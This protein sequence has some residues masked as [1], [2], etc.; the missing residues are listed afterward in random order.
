MT[1]NQGCFPATLFS[2][3][4]PATMEHSTRYP[5]A[6]RIEIVASLKIAVI[7][8][9]AS[10]SDDRSNSAEKSTR[11]TRLLLLRSLITLAVGACSFLIFN[12]ALPLWFQPTVVGLLWGGLFVAGFMLGSLRSGVFGAVCASAVCSWLF[13]YCFM[14][15][16]DLAAPDC[17]L[18]AS[19][20]LSCG[21]LTARLDQWTVVK[22]SASNGG[23]T[24]PSLR[25]WSI[26]D[27]VFVT[28]MAACFCKS[29]PQL[30]APPVL[31]LSVLIALAAGLVCSW[32]AYR[33]AWNDD[34]SLRR[35]LLVASMLALI[36][37]YLYSYAPTGMS[38]IEAV[39]WMISGPVNVIAAQAVA[40]L[41][42]LALVRFELTNAQPRLA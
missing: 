18:I 7:E 42:A 23:E 25:Q 28:T 35:C 27:I 5:P 10:E 20:L 8:V 6:N 3:L 14:E 13:G 1:E 38:L 16:T 37:V 30:A 36:T 29:L 17:L 33:W 21:W 2:W 22:R 26:S 31:L 4:L 9:D 40:V 19:L 34:W 32:I 39:S 15:I 11:P 41:F 12:L 24:R